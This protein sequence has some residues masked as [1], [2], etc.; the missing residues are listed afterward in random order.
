VKRSEL[1]G[2]EGGAIVTR[3][4]GMEG[5]NDDEVRRKLAALA[6]GTLA[7]I[8]GHDDESVASD[9]TGAASDDPAGEAHGDR[10]A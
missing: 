6:K 1:T 4:D 2:A 3:S 8:E 9:E 5:V 7:V 10:D